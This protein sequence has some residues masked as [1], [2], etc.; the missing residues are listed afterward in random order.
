MIVKCKLCGKR[1]KL[2]HIVLK[3]KYYWCGNCKTLYIHPF[4]SEKILS[5]YYKNS[6][7][8]PAGEKNE[9]Q[10]RKRAQL[11]LNRLINLNPQGSKLLDIGSGYGYFLDEAHK[12]RLII[13]G[14][15]PSIKLIKKS[16]HSERIIHDQFPS[17]KLLT[18]KFDFITII[19]VIEHVQNPKH[20]IK[21]AIKLLHPNGVLF[22]E[23]P[24]L[25]S[26]LYNFQQKHFTFLTPPDHLWVL[27][28]DSF[29]NTLPNRC[30]ICKVSTY[31]YPE[32]FMGIL[33]SV[34][35]KTKYQTDNHLLIKNIS[36]RA[37]NRIA[38]QSH[39]YRCCYA[40]NKYLINSLAI[41]NIFKTVKYLIFDL[42]IARLFYRLLNI[43]Q[44]GSILELHIRVK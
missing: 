44:Y 17:K 8:Y 20:M 14:I 26:H 15:E 38:K 29:I 30:K 7:Q 25:N 23:T 6:F 3:F 34:V 31:S 1:T 37:N 33:K 42:V 36:L 10:I 18:F 13:S 19:H 2:K 32:H 21:E 9:I 40:V 35:N 4:P 24:N 16:L 11:I 27:S 5:Q 22:I 39:Q 12:K 41:I 28:K 43:K